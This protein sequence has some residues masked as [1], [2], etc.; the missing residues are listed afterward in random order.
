MPFIV[1]N[2]LDVQIAI[3]DRNRISRMIRDPIPYHV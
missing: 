3:C 2:Y 1:L